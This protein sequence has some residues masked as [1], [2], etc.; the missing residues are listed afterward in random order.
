MAPDRTLVLCKPDAV[1]RV[2][3]VLSSSGESVAVL[4]KV[5]PSTGEHRVVYNGHLDL[6]A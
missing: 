5:I 1:E 4:G 6:T 2:S 3:E